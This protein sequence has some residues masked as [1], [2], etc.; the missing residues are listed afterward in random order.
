[1]QTAQYVSHEHICVHK[2]FTLPKLIR[3]TSAGRYVQFMG[4]LRSR[5]ML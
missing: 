5:N 4:K 1:M 2:I 3:Q